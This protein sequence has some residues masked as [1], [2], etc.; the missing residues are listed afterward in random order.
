M[1]ADMR[2]ELTTLTPAVP[3]AGLVTAAAPLNSCN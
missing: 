2:A 3:T 1:L